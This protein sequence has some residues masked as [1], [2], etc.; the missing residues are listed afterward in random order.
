MSFFEETNSQVSCL[1]AGLFGFQGAGK[2]YTAVELAIGMTNLR[3]GKKIAFFDTENG[4]Q[5]HIKRVEKEGLK[6]VIKKSRSFKDALKSIEFAKSEGCSAL[7]IDSVSHIWKELTDSY[8]NAKKERILKRFPNNKNPQV[9]LTLKDWGPLKGMWASFTDSY[10]LSDLDILVCGRA[11]DTFDFNED[12]EGKQEIV[13]TGTKMKAEKEFG[14]EPDLLIELWQEPAMKVKKGKSALVNKCIILKDRNQIMNGH[15]IDMPKFASFK[16]IIDLIDIKG[17]HFAFDDKAT[18]RELIGNPDYSLRDADR[19][20]QIEIEN[21]DSVLTKAGLSGTAQEA[22][23][24]RVQALEKAFGTSAKT[25]IESM[26]LDELKMGV[27][28]LQ[29]NL[30]LKAAPIPPPSNGTND[31]I[32]MWDKQ[33]DY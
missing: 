25:A 16:K 12:E 28:Q 30:G 17:T 6:L 11:G 19:L 33:V 2:T 15:I 26:E 31:Q 21:L 1:K 4:A 23:L 9:N 10:M 7:V 8:L 14:Y 3:K 29:I 24:K 20:K 27:E 13:K 18:S 5:F 32:P 22:K